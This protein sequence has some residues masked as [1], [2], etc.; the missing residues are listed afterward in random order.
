MLDLA[1]RDGFETENIEH[2]AGVIRYG[3]AGKRSFSLVPLG[4]R[5]KSS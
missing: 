4:D 2:A 5:H 1:A 3:K